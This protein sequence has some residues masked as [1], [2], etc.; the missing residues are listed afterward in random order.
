M[1]PERYQQIC[2][3]YFAAS[4][5]P[6]ARR[7]EFLREACGADDDLR[8]EAESLLA[9]TEYAT[10]FFDGS[11]LELAAGALADEQQ[12]EKIGREFAHYKI[13]GL[14][15]AGGMGEV[16]LAEDARL[17]R[18]IALKLLHAAQ[19]DFKEDRLKRFEQEARAVSAL[20]HPNII[21]IFDIGESDGWQFIATELVD[22]KTLRQTMQGKSLPAR[23]AVEIAEQIAAAL[24]AAHSAGIVH[25]DIKP[26]NVMIRRDRIVKVLDFGLARF[27]EKSQPLDR[28]KSKFVTTPGMIM[29]TA[30]YMSPEQAR[31]LPVDERTDVFSLGIVL[32]EMLTGRTPFQGTSEIDVLAAIVQREPDELGG[33]FPA[34]LRQIVDRA[35]RK[36][37]DE[38]FRTASEMLDELRRVKRT[39]DFQTELKRQNTA[40]TPEQMAIT[41]EM[42]ALTNSNNARATNRFAKTATAFKSLVSARRA[43]LPALVL[44]VVAALGAFSYFRFFAAQNATAAVLSD[45]DRILIADFEN[46][47][48]DDDFDNILRQPLAVGLAQSPFFAIVPDGQIRQTLKL[49]DKPS[50]EKL[51]RETALEICR[52]RGVKAFLKGT[53]ENYG[54]QY[55]LTLEA[56]NGN[57]GEQIAL[58][59]VEAKTKD[60]VLSALND[61]TLKMRRKLGESIASIEKFDAPIQTSSSASLDALRTYT[62]A[63]RS[64]QT[65]NVDESNNLLKRAIELDPQ[66]AAA[67]AALAVGYWN[68]EQYTLAAEYAEKAYNL[69]ERATEREKLRFSD[70]YFAFVTG[71][72]DK[73]IET[74]EVYKQTYP[75][76][77]LPPANLASAYMTVGQF[78][79]AEENS[80]ASIAIDPQQF[81]PFTTLAQALL[82]QSRFDEAR[83]TI[84]DAFERGFKNEDFNAYLFDIA[85]VNNDEAAMREQIAAMRGTPSEE[86]ALIWQANAAISRGKLRDYE[87]FINQTIAKIEKDQP[88]R[89]AVFAAQAAVNFA[90]AGKCENAKLQANRALKF[91]RAQQILTDAALS[92]ALCSEPNENLIAEV[93]QRFPKNTVANEI[94]LPIVR[95]ASELENQPDKAIETLEITKRYEGASQFWDNYLR[96]RAFAKLN[97]TD[98]A[99]A[100]FEKILNNRGWSPSSPLFA[101]ASLEL[102]RAYN[103]RNDAESAEKYRTE[104]LERWKNADADL[105]VLKQAR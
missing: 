102:S 3:I 84:E 31:A 46:K 27:T 10:H 7:A 66:F 104:F 1:T 64:N 23:E 2:D 16:W 34:E 56:F 12:R 5:L 18:R 63:F 87:R 57:S 58:E 59:K 96:G 8:R 45:S 94:W 100:E 50:D 19:T 11:A 95:A 20:N 85:L 91:E 90:A 40:E 79:K 92:F 65:G 101:L 67:Y 33:D 99:V 88:D 68:K 89:A 81:V 60:Q 39:L 52:R 51:T 54:V 73:D 25:R 98:L 9:S 22:G 44:L 61:A 21:T 86:T 41:R 55:L 53:I 72:M 15:G 97:R 29:G 75:R 36:N 4:E 43:A 30:S 77:N 74:L 37:S 70:F 14:L 13:V 76:D 105:P 93:K 24:A 26:E 17:K 42:N 62:A 48:G 103:L 82:R 83:A 69:R 80:R 38:R 49:M 35:L 78:Q 32:Y 71:E 28:E 6:F 47:T